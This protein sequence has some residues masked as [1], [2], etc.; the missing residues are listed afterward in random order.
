LGR[1]GGGGGG[2]GEVRKAI[3][4]SLKLM[5]IRERKKQPRFDKILINY[6]RTFF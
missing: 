6:L 1:I 4:N 3:I 5:E 2:G